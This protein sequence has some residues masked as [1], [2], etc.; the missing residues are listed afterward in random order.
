MCWLLWI[1]AC[2][3][4]MKEHLASGVYIVVSKIPNRSVSKK[5]ILRLTG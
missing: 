3:K 2:T 4:K 5:N 1:K